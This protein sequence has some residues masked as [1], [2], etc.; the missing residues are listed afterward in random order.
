[1]TAK[2]I[3]NPYS[4]RWNSQKRWPEAEKALQDAGVDFELAISSGPGNIAELT[5]IAVEQGFSPIIAAGGD[6]TIGEVVNAMAQLTM[7]KTELTP[8]GILP[9]GTAN[10]LAFALK[11]PFDLKEAVKVIATGNVKMMDLGK[12]NN[13]Y[14]ANNSALGLEP[15]VTVIQNKITWIKGI[16][17]YL[18]AAVMAIM[19]RPT[20]NAH[21]EWD[22]GSYNGPVSLIYIGNGPRSGG[23][24]F[25]GPH[26]D[27]FDGK[28]TI[29]YG[30]RATRRGMFALLP[31]TMK[32]AEGS[33]VES[34]GMYE[35]PVTW[36][37]VHLEN[38][39]PAHTD[40]ELFSTGIQDLEYRVFPGRLP[41]VLP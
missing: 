5:R 34:E 7:G 18:V 8:I 21:M 22:G 25:M 39:S 24:F 29:V 1:M 31:K 17:R 12:A 30:H 14:F 35:F 20:W 11:V 9:L 36:L 13:I 27:P 16:M 4:N 3:L 19:D 10:D 6:G 2:V 15:Y 40:G 26:A 33:Y 37:K 41:M 28:L 23:V 32:P 38:P